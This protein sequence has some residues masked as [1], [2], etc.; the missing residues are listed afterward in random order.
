MASPS[1]APEDELRSLPQR[2]KPSARGRALIFSSF[3][4]TMGVACCLPSIA[5][6]G[7]TK[8]LTGIEALVMGPFM[9]RLGQYSWMANVLGLLGLERVIQGGR[10]AAAAYCV[11]ALGLAVQAWWMV[12]Q[13][14][15]IADGEFAKVASLQAGFY[16]WLGALAL[17]LVCAV[18]LAPAPVRRGDFS[19]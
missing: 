12:G 15:P 17:P 10:F 19:A 5:F 6:E 2:I 8:P 16:V 3:V 18:L 1:P 4:F 14:V 13:V 7:P 9:L 11:L